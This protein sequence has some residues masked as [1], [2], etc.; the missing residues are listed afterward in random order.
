MLCTVSFLMPPFTLTYFLLFVND[1]VLSHTQYMH[2]MRCAWLRRQND[3]PSCRPSKRPTTHDAVSLSANPSAVA[4]SSPSS[5]RRC[6]TRPSA[7]SPPA[8]MPPTAAAASFPCPHP[9][10]AGNFG[11]P[12]PPRPGPTALTAARTLKPPHDQ[13]RCLAVRNRMLV[14]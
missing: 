2:G 10:A 13:P 4:S 11:K 9:S 1:I 3:M 8:A 12:P 5:R 7:P 14:A 6:S